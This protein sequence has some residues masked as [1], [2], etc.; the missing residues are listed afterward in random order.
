MPNISVIICTRNPR[1]D[2]LCRVLDALEVQT[3][4]KEQWELLVV[5]NASKERLAETW[6]LKWHPHAR[7]IREEE[8]GLSPAR[9]RGI[10]E[11][12]GELLIF[13]D[14]DNI[15]TPNFLETA[16]AIMAGYDF[17]GVFGAGILE[18]EFEVQPPSELLSRL[19]KLSLRYV[20][21]FC[22][23]SDIKDFE[24]IPWGA[25]L[26]VTRS[27]ADY[28]PQF[29]FQLNAIDLLDRK[30]ERLFAGGDDLFSW[31]SVAVGKGFGLFPELRVTHLISAGRLSHRYFLRLIHDHA[32][33]HGVLKYLIGGVYP[34]RVGLEQYVRLIIHGIKNG[35]L[36]GI[37]N[38]LF[39]AKC[40]WAGVYG[41]EV[42]SRFITERQLQPIKLVL[43]P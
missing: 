14:D 19:D 32:F 25:G 30:E 22:W 38:G 23:S 20:K 40:R 18:P 13:V 42:A 36:H 24:Y 37:K 35:L 26:C 10:K 21:K 9:L 27:V 33:S 34:Q 1:P 41:S 2:Y 39:S 17:L 28:Y 7:H 43:P 12:Y 31:A 5:D 4:P 16:W 15:L 3:F 8:P 29:V 6:D 11:S